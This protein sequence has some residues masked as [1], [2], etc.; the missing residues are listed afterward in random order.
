MTTTSLARRLSM[1]KQDGAIKKHLL[2]THNIIIN[3]DILDNNTKILYYN[4]DYF[5]LKIAESL[6]IDKCKP[7]INIQQHLFNILPTKRNL[8][9][10]ININNV[11]NDNISIS[12]N[13][14]VNNNNNNII[15]DNND[16][17]GD[18]ADNDNDVENLINIDDLTIP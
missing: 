4:N 7:I 10:N 13:I 2:D 11:N 16:D 6:F 5:K 12:S 18:I 14:N 1:H 15:N 9:N 8:L 17:D 3:R